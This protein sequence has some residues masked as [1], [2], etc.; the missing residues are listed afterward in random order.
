MRRLAL[1]LMLG[2]CAPASR[3]AP[4]PAGLVS[5]PAQLDQRY[6]L[7]TR[8]HTAA[9]QVV[10][11]LDQLGAV[12]R[13]S[14]EAT[15]RCLGAGATPKGAT[16]VCAVESLSI[17]AGRVMSAQP[18][19][20][21]AAAALER[22]W[23]DAL[24]TLTVARDGR[25]RAD[26]ASLPAAD[27]SGGPPAGAGDHALARLLFRAF[28]APVPH[29][30]HADGWTWRAAADLAPGAPTAPLLRSTVA[31]RAGPRTVVES[32]LQASRDPSALRVRHVH[33]AE[34]GWLVEGA[35]A[36]TERERG[37]EAAVVLSRFE[38]AT[39]AA[40]NET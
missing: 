20:T 34:V 2:S 18:A 1:P 4:R 10:Q 17:D 15:V 32:R 23:S 8:V 14:A 28:D 3:V 16:V 19:P 21:T 9:P 25:V 38:P 11:Q 29:D 30:A 26:E 37:L 12:Q 40:L 39:D 35:S 31:L 27:V 6:D 7:A 36:W 24:V 22:R 13:F 33:D 5:A